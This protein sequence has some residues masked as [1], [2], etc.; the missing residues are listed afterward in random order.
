MN[1]HHMALFVRNCR[2][3]LLLR[4]NFNEGDLNIFS[5]AEWRWKIPQACDNE[6]HHYTVNVDLPKVELFIDG[7]KFEAN[8]EDRHSNP[9]VIDD[10]PLHAAHGVNT[11]LTIA[12]CYQGTENRLKHGFSGD[13][14][15]IKLSLRKILTNDEI[16]C[17]TDCAEHLLPPPEHYLE[18]EQQIQTNTQLNE[19]TIEGNNENNI[20][21][22]LQHIQYINRKREPTI[23][24]RNIE[25]KTT[26]TCANKK[27][28]R[29]PTIDSYIMLT[30]STVS[31]K[32]PSSSS[33]FN[34]IHDKPIS[35]E[36]K[37]QIK[38]IGNSN[39]LVS[40]HD[41]KKGVKILSNIN[42]TIYSAGHLKYN[43]QK[44]DECSVTVFPSLNPDHEEISIEAG[45]NLSPI[46]DIKTTINKDGAE[47]IGYDSIDN[48]FKVLKSLIYINK[49]P[50]YYLNRVFKLSCAQANTHFK[51]A[52]FTLTLTVL[53]PKQKQQN[54]TTNL[55][56]LVQQHENSY[57]RAMIHSH[58]IHE[59]QSKISTIRQNAG[60]NSHSTMLIAVICILFVVLICGV[61]IARLR[62][63]TNKPIVAKHQPCSKVRQQNNN[64]K[65]CRF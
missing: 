40:Y 8:T 41:I 38:I 7:N 62:N 64:N 2:L 3:I 30:Q 11:T 10:W 23:G 49:K 37:P 58:E 43:L 17:G 52:E 25:I 44:L 51:S 56:I 63:N 59:P 57:A 19:I 13:I 42:I 33:A 29:L 15:E 47:L 39:N 32:E 61:G 50:A 5:P 21:M 35:D 14:S 9:E 4:K 31:T 24:R 1:R 28:V 27:S 55:P 22:L 34:H 20:E 65:K 45:E 60:Q 48:Y 16:K 26:V 54:L 18:P 6:W 46:L 12:A 36:Q 53:H